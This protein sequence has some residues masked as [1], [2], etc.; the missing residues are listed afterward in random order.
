MFRLRATIYPRLR[1]LLS[2]RL[3]GDRKGEVISALDK[4]R[5]LSARQGGGR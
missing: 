1:V 2:F 4:S 3:R 5:A